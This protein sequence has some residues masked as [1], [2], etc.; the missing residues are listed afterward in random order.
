MSYEVIWSEN[1]SLDLIDIVSYI[2]FNSGK[3]I[4]KGIYTKIKRKV[5]KIID[6]PK[7]GIIVP[8]LYSIGITDIYQIMESPW[9]IYYKIL[10]DKILVLS[11]IDGRRNLEEILYKKII[12]NR[13]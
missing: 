8:E 2:K 1:A 4:A 13:N 3:G 7:K 11:V 12:T 10:E 5:D 6:F 9:K